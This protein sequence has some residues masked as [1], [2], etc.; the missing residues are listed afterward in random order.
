MSCSCPALRRGLFLF[1][2]TL[3]LFLFLVQSLRFLLFPGGN[4]NC[5]DKDE[6][7]ETDTKRGGAGAFVLSSWRRGVAGRQRAVD[8]FHTKFT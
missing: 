3:D 2:E 7:R 4:R 6:E 1:L 8:S 5:S